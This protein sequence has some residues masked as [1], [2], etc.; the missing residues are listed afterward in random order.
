MIIYKLF[1]ASILAVAAGWG[2]QNRCRDETEYYVRKHKP[3]RKTALVDPL[4]LPLY[5]AILLG[6]GLLFNG[7][8]FTG[9]LMVRLCSVL[10][11]Y[12]SIYF[13]L[14]LCLLP[15]LRHFISARACATL[16]LLP[17]LLYMVIS[18]SSV[19][20]N[21]LL[22][23]TLPR[24]WLTLSAWVWLAGFICVLLWQILSHLRFRHALLQNAI[25]AEDESV[26]SQWSR[27]Q[28]LGRVKRPFPL[29]ISADINTPVSIGLFDQTLRIVLP[30]Q[31]YSEKELTLI[32]RHELRHIQRLDIRTKAFL[33]FCTAMCW[34]NPLMWIAR[35]RAS[36]DLELSCDEAVLADAD[37]STRRRYAGLLLNAAGSSRGYTTCLS[38]S[39]GSLRYRLKNVV[40]PRRR[41]S[42]AAAVSFAMLLLIMGYGTVAL[43]DS[44]GT[45]QTLILDKAPSD[46]IIESVKINNWPEETADYQN[47]YGWNEDALTSYLASL[48]VR[49]V[50]TGNYSDDGLRQL[51]VDY[52]IPRGA[53][54]SP[55]TRFELCDGLLWA[56]IPYD[57]YG[58]LV[59]ILEDQV[60]WDYIE[61]LLDRNA[62]DP[63]PAPHPPEM[64]MYFNADAIRDDGPMYAA[65][66]IL[67]LRS[68]G[69]DQPVPDDLRA[70]EIGGVSGFPVTDVQLTFS[71]APLDGYRVQ[72]ENW[73]RT[74]AYFV[75][76]E[77]L[78]GSALP[79]APYS[80]H[81]T[82]Y[83]TFATVRETVYEM[84]FAFDVTLPDE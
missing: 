70:S 3:G 45:V 62:P 29:L 63:D 44:G 16:W 17:N 13:A 36:D 50:Y 60:D 51:Y 38:A 19:E 27:E 80:A 53:S 43:A 66:T 9:T 73:E 1:L 5:L 41:Y 39:A 4:L 55:V 22:V 52:C 67:S 26:L 68:G 59:Y 24:R 8:S 14:L 58:D 64:M 46:N 7:F 57:N 48:R 77:E 56:N 79:L 61:S 31:R 72:V 42:G 18:V 40:K 6:G 32:F 82:V 78:S 65:K 2:F 74:S 10:L 20:T 23:L 33:G 12:I 69:E 54:D 75:S 76:S 47:V 81:Y 30:A 15:L 34:F 71:Y 83:G 25:P 11:L 84:K 37:E 21:P 28:N 35:R 49:P